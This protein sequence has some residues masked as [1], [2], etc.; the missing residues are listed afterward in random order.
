MPHRRRRIQISLNGN[1]L[2]GPRAYFAMARDGVF[3]RGLCKIDPKY[4]T[5]ANAIIFFVIA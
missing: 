4:Q 5:P 1:A 3:P 2:S